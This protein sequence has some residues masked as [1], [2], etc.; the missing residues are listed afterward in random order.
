MR[1]RDPQVQTMEAGP[2]MCLLGVGSQAPVADVIEDVDPMLK[3][4]D[5]QGGDADLGQLATLYACQQ[6]DGGAGQDRDEIDGRIKRLP[7]P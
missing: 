2:G 4:D 6:P 5:G 3:Q 7:P 1:R